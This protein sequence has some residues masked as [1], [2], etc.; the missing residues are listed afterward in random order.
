MKL[1]TF[2]ETLLSKTRPITDYERP[3]NEGNILQTL[4]ENFA[5]LHILKNELC[6]IHKFKETFIKIKITQDAKRILI[7]SETVSNY[8][9]IISYFSQIGITKIINAP[10][11][12]TCSSTSLT[13][14]VFAIFPQIISQEGVML[15]YQTTNSSITLRNLINLKLQVCTKNKF[16]S[17]KN[18]T[19]NVIKMKIKFAYHEY[20]EDVNFGCSHF[21]KK[22]LKTIDNLLPDKAKE[23][24]QRINK[25]LVKFQITFLLP[26]TRVTLSRIL[27]KFVIRETKHFL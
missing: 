1:K 5:K 25:G 12:I 24:N 3:S 11:C 4:N 20:F 18:Y 22:L 15:L 9:K 17:P 27:D 10:T 23:H 26:F 19:L 8:A 21:F 14:D 7:V 13:D 6:I 16:R 2:F